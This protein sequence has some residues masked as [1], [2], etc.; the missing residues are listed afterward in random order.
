MAESTLLAMAKKFDKNAVSVE[1]LAKCR[2]SIY[3]VFCP[4][5]AFVLRLTDEQYRTA[6]QIESELNF[7]KYLF[8]NGAA[9][10]KPLQTESGKSCLPFEMNGSRFWVSAFDYIDGKGWDERD[11]NSEEAFIKIGRALGKIHNL[12]KKYIPANVEK[13]RLWSEQQELIN[14]D[15]L[16][17]YSLKL[18]EK[19]LEFMRQMETSEKNEDNFGLTHGDFLS[20]NYIFNENNITV[21]D[22]DECEYSWFAAD[23]AICMRCY[24]FWTE[25]PSELPQK[26]KEAE[27]MHYNLLLGY[28]IENKI[29]KEMVFDLE[30]FI[31]IR[32]FIELAQL[33]RQEKLNGIEK[34]LFKMNLD[35][36]L[37]NK[38]FLIFNTAKAEK[39]LNN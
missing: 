34:T 32:D 12:S 37:N 38:P 29:S 31:R 1:F 3:K 7:Q 10:V 14:A 36:V 5:Y 39:L 13:R 35:R 30:K 17:N 33:L 6:G 20:S 2:N 23:L 21:F 16:K 8:D 28:S 27:F 15:V 24:L 19:L 11:D 22:F 26:E 25:R 18:Y 9:V 4:D